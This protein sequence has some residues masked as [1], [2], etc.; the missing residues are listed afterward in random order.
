MLPMLFCSGPIPTGFSTSI[1]TFSRSSPVL[2]QHID[3]CALSKPDGCG[4]PINVIR[5]PKEDKPNPLRGATS[6]SAEQK[7]CNGHLPERNLAM[8]TRRNFLKTSGAA[9]AGLLLPWKI[10]LTSAFAQTAPAILDPASLPKYVTPLVIPP[11]MPRTSKILR[12]KG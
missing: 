7:D 5:L 2:T 12:K 11:A 10:S 9:G 1:R 3:G 8:I 6:H 4:K